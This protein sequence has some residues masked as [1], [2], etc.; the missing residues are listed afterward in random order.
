MLPFDSGFRT[1]ILQ[2]MTQKKQL[3]QLC[4]MEPGK[5]ARLPGWTEQIWQSSLWRVEFINLL[6]HIVR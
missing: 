4:C 1:A 5:Q 3:C 2:R 6:Q